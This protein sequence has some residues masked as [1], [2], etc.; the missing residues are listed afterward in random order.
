M[1]DTVMKTFYLRN[2]STPA[3]LQEAAATLKSILDVTRVQL[4]PNQNAM[5]LRGTTDQMVLAQKLLTDIDKPKPEVVIDI[6]VLQVSR[7]RIRTMGVN[8]PTSANVVLVPGVGAVAG[9]GSG[10]GSGG[11]TFTFNSLKTING[12][13]FQVSFPGASLSFLMSDSDTKLLQNPEIR[14]LDNEKA[15]LK[16]GDRVPV[17]TGSFGAGGGFGGSALVNTQ[18]QYL[19]VGVNIDIT[20]HIHSDHEVTLKMTLEISSVSGTQ[21]IGGISQPIIGQMEK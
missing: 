10:S 21:N 11:N 4:I 2:V 7:N 20:P 14:A 15:T 1:E 19:D 17:A 13:N 6:A 16:I 12:N 9:V 8:P 3:E 18:F 5:I